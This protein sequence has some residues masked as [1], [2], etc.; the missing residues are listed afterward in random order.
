MAEKSVRLLVLR[1]ADSQVSHNQ[2]FDNLFKILISVIEASES[3]RAQ[4]N[5]GPGAFGLL[6]AD[7]SASKQ[8]QAL[9]AKYVLTNLKILEVVL[10]KGI[11]ELCTLEGAGH[12]SSSHAEPGP[13][14]MVGSGAPQ[15]IYEH[16]DTDIVSDS[17]SQDQAGRNCVQN[18]RFFINYLKKYVD[19]MP[20]IRNQGSLIGFLKWIRI[21]FAKEHNILESIGGILDPVVKIFSQEGEQIPPQYFDTNDHMQILQSENL[22][23]QGLPMQPLKLHQHNKSH[24]QSLP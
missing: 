5:S 2:R 7:A 8:E 15:G 3:K 24:N 19:P 22:N 13:T 12:A 20:S 16:L 6:D 14:V 4:M 23:D 21:R 10:F 9:L 18:A 17:S 11:D 1:V